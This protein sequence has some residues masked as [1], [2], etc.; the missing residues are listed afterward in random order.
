MGGP[1]ITPEDIEVWHCRASQCTATAPAG[2]DGWAD[3]LGG[4]YCGV[5][6]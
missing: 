5:H 6:G 3:D 4:P 1:E 2:A